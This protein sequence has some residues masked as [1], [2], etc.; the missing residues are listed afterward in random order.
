MGRCFKHEVHM[1]GGIRDTADSASS[2]WELPNGYQGHR[3][4]GLSH[5]QRLESRHLFV[6]VFSPTRLFFIV[7]IINQEDFVS[8]HGRSSQPKAL[9]IW[10]PGSSLN[11]PSLTHL[12]LRSA[13][14]SHHTASCRLG[15]G[16][17][18]ALE[19][20]FLG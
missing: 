14:Q 3:I 12:A 10:I 9:H 19:L 13:H 5:P 18:C 7:R 11:P 6:H 8:Q 15:E 16:Q 4:S 2:I 20:S 17:E 1:E